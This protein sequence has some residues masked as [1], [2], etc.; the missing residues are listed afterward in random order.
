M[1]KIKI[2]T[3]DEKEYETILYTDD[4]IKV[5]SIKIEKTDKKK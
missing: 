1:Y 5:K 3:L 4:D 2:I